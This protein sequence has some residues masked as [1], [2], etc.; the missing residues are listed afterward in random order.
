M[1]NPQ[2]SREMQ[3]NHEKTAEIHRNPVKPNCQCQKFKN[4]IVLV[5]VPLLV[6]VL[7]LML[8]LPPVPLLM[9]LLPLHTHAHTRTTH[10]YSRTFTSVHV[11]CSGFSAP[12]SEPAASL[13]RGADT[14]FEDMVSI[15][16]IM[17][18]SGAI[19]SAEHLA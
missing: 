10:T 7:L 2:N 16:G 6:P 11:V 5:W 13:Q 18:V 19:G 12:C 15:G 4:L 1:I 17:K 8:L 3:R 9:L 14:G